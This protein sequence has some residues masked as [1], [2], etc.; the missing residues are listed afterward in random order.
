MPM[1]FCESDSQNQTHENTASHTHSG[2]GWG[3]YKS[4]SQLPQ[5]DPGGISTMWIDTAGTL[6]AGSQL[7]VLPAA[8]II[9]PR[10]PIDS[11][12][13]VPSNQTTGPDL[14]RHLRPPSAGQ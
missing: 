11:C 5:G 8:P 12:S 13:T 9:M 2:I 1:V 7:T 14:L 4:V 10:L 6:P 3:C